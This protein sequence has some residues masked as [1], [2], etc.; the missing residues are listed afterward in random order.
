MKDFKMIIFCLFTLFASVSCTEDDDTG[1][2]TSKL[3]VEGW[4][5]DGGFPVV[6]LSRSLPV[7]NEFVAMSDLSNYILRW[8]KVTI[9]DGIDSVVLTGKYDAGYFPP[10]IYTTSRMKGVAGKNYTLTV[11]YRNEKVTACTTIPKQPPH[12]SFI[13]ERCANSDTL[14]QM[15]ANFVDIPNEK[16]FYQFFVR[17]G[18][19]SKQYLAS[20]LGSIDDEV[21]G[22]D[23]IKVPIYRG[24]QLREKD[25]TPYFSV[26]DTVSIK[27]AQVDEM[28]FHIWDSYTKNLSL[29]QN[30]F[31]STYSNLPSNIIGGYGYWCGYGSITNHFMISPAIVNS[32]N[33]LYN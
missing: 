4:I 28:T 15:T 1:D 8:A 12:C 19:H 30:M 14:F 20:Y 31:L 9:S 13:V 22:H 27:F 18:T 17:V 24:H 2:Y 32:K 16:N 10:Y 21:V 6:M 7:N 29:S 11:E 5:E 23:V 3:V 33:N 25:Y 26:N